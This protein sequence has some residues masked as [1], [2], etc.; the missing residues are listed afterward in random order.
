MVRIKTIPD[1]TYRLQLNSQFTFRQAT[2]LIPHLHRLG[3]SHCYASPYLKARPGS[4]HGYDIVDHNALNPEIGSEADYEH[5]VDE[6]HRHRMGLIT[7]IVPNHMGIMGSDNDWWLDVLENGPASDYAEFFDIDWHPLKKPLQNKLL[8]PV[9][10]D[11]YG[12]IMEQRELRLKFDADSG[13]FSVYYYHHRFPIDPKT[14]PFILNARHAQLLKIFDP[15]DPLLLEYQTLDGSFRKL[16]DRT[17]ATTAHREERNRDKEV[18]KRQL[19]RLCREKASIRQFIDSRVAEIND[20]PDAAAG[21]DKLHSLLE[22][23]AYRLA[24]WRVA[25]DEINYRRFFDIND[26]AGLRVEEERVFNASHQFILALIEQGKTQGLRLDHADGLYDPVD[27]NQ[28]LNGHI[29]A[30]MNA[31]ADSKA[32]PIYIVA[33]KIVANYEYLSHDWPIH[34]TTGYE[35]ANAVNGLF[36]NPEAEKQFTAIYDRFVGWRIDFEELVYQAK[37]LVMTTALAAEWNILAN[38]LSQIAETQSKT[39]D[40]TLNALRDALLEVIACFPVYRTYIN[41]SAVRKE[42]AQYIEWAIAQARRRSRAADKSVFDFIQR[43][44]LV[45]PYSPESESDLVSFVKKFQQYTAPVMAKGHEDTALYQ[46][47][48]L[49]TLNEVGGDP[50]HFGYSVNAFHFFNQERVKKWPHAMLNLSTH[51]SKHGADVRARI[52]VLTEIPEQWQ[53][54]VLHWHRLNQARSLTS[55]AISRND[56]YLFYQILLGTWPLM[57]S[58]GVM[59]DTYRERIQAYMLKAVREA[60]QY[61]SWHNPDQGYEQAISDFVCR[62]LDW[63]ANHVFL[64]NFTAFEKRLRRAGLYNALAQTFLVLTSPGVPDIYQGNEIWQFSLVD[65]DNRRSIDF[66]TNR[67]LLS[68]LDGVPGGDRLPLLKSLLNAPEDGRIKL[69]LT[70]QTLRLRSQYAALFEN[71]EYLKLSI[72]GPRSDNLVAFARRDPE[73]FVVILVPR[74]MKHLLDEDD[75]WVDTRLELPAD[76]PLHFSNIFTNGKLSAK[77]VDGHLELDIEDML[78]A[79]PVAL[80]MA[81]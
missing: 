16:P 20:R 32:P 61:S 25:G 74:L 71:G 42:D 59:L 33:E 27:Y 29:A 73:Q 79:F 19:A 23:Q 75:I 21:I 41:S 22:Q 70:A 67:Q 45:Q 60:K 28:R 51:D 39:R 3:I 54:A 8:I 47:N 52:N 31:D 24:Y 69:F 37:K 53:N 1:A 14:Y 64:D 13:E 38:R 43:V 4:T 9:L 18:F 81:G 48:R 63:K 46:Y 68:T 55:T 15:T 36:V 11:H 44:L 34:G 6:L 10:G 57:L 2:A 66:E 76:A 49:I 77:A 62:C 17:T 58:D 26:L 12:N 78:E 7:D 40:Y 56:E 50:R 80:L 72:N 30:I 5:F 35:F 65:P